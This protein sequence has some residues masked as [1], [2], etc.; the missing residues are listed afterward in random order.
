MNIKITKISI[1][2]LLIIIILFNIKPILAQN[3]NNIALT[4]TPPLIKINMNPG[5]TWSSSIK[6]INNNAQK[7]TVYTQVLDFKGDDKG[8]VKFI[9]DYNNELSKNERS[10]LLSQWIEINQEP[11]NLEPYQSNDIFFTIKVPEQAEPGGHYAAILTGTKATKKIEEGSSIGISS[12]LTSLIMLKINGEI[13]EKGRIEEFSTDK[14]F[15]QTPEIDF[16][17]RFANLGNVH[18]Q[19][20]G[21][22][23]IYNFLGK[24]KK[25][26]PINQKSDFGNVLPDNTRKW[27]FN[28]KGENSLLDMG[29]FKADLV[30]TFGEEAKQNSFQTLYFWV[31]NLKPIL[32]I[33]S[34]LL[35][36]LFLIIYF[37]RL[38]IKKSVAMVQKQVEL[39]ISSNNKASSISNKKIKSNNTKNK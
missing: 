38:Y 9:K 36:F 35:F 18:L 13:N 21:E 27:Q 10:H 2:S 34:I 4:I 22:I 6:I 20:Q 5:E 16:T 39:N 25:T 14:K 15:Y 32:I 23:I 11:I 28:W 33:L 8:G 31:I 1:I 12:M 17:V 37:T 7:L 30:L 24:V 29:R 3:S 19:P 26:I